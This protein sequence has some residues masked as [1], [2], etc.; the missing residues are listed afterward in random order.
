[1]RRRVIVDPRFQ[2]SLALRAG[3]FVVLLLVGMSIG[4][5]L[6]LVREIRSEGAAGGPPE[7][8]AMVMLYMHS[9]FWQL[10]ASFLALAVLSV[11]LLSHRIAGPLVRIRRCL[12][13]V[14]DKKL[15]PPLRL[16][17]KD[18]LQREAVALNTM[19]ASLASNLGELQAASS[20]TRRLLK[21]TSALVEQQTNPE[22]S[23]SLA[24]V[25]VS[26]G[27]LDGRLSSFVRGEEQPSQVDWEPAPLPVPTP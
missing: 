23:E 27:D 2:F 24:A 11:V 21:T 18:Y 13:A 20:R 8:Q 1:M 12:L 4:L 6:P 22:L 15:P 5:F 19:V 3:V 7:S 16:R 17:D 26:L 25:A 10:A 9:H 14:A